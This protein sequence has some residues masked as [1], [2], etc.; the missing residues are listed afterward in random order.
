MGILEKFKLDGK[1]AFIT[2][3]SRGLGKAMAEAIGQAGGNVV[4]VS[5]NVEECK[6]VAKEIEEK[7][8]KKSL[9]MKVD[10]R[11][12][13]EIE[14]AV[15]KT[16]EEFG[17][18]DILITSAG[19]NIRKPAETFP[20][21][22]FSRIIDTNFYGTWHCCRIVGK[23]MIERRYGRII[24]IGSILSTVTLPERTA[25]S[26]SKGGVLQLTKTLAVEWAKYNITV[27]CICPG[28]FETAINEKIFKNPEIRKFF[29]ERIPMGRFG[30]VEEVGALAVFLS[31]DACPYIT[32]TAIYIDG[33][34]TAL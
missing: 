13:K 18:I 19:I 23:Y 6:K 29:L 25:Y 16:I 7:T 12:Q 21:D 1:V 8:G 3:G 17:K 4:V 2:G 33:G 24:T 14:E 30:K 28:P 11:N 22:E 10:V 31:S 20:F 32:G 9:G 5:R 27:N 34:W 15:K 26:S